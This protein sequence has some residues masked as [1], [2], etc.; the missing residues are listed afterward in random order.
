MPARPL[1]KA[2]RSGSRASRGFAVLGF[3]VAL[4]A[5]LELAA[6]SA[7]MMDSIARGQA[8]VPLAEGRP[9]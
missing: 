2:P 7:G 8:T 6:A 5:G 1:G 9:S 4:L 3:V